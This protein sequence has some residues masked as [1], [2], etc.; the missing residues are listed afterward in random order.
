LEEEEE[1]RLEEEEEKNKP[2]I[3]HLAMLNAGLG[4]QVTEE[5]K[6]A[7]MT[8]KY[9][10]YELMLIKINHE[11]AEGS[12]ESEKRKFHDWRHYYADELVEL[13]NRFQPPSY[14]EL[15][16]HAYY[17]YNRKLF[18]LGEDL[19]DNESALGDATFEMDAHF[20]TTKVDRSLFSSEYQ[21]WLM[22][23]PTGRHIS[24]DIEYDFH[25][26]TESYDDSEWITA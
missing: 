1:K 12:V 14:T 11:I 9:D 13:Y 8:Q 20:F 7:L 6:K 4:K 25:Q 10:P 16:K 21:Y 19:R 5:D 22:S 26:D 17:T 23:D 24:Q 18:P 15:C 2:M 3:S